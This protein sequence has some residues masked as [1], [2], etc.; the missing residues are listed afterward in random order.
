VARQ[1]VFI[2]ADTRNCEL[3]GRGLCVGE[4]L[5]GEIDGRTVLAPAVR[6]AVRSQL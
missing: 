1:H 4:A 6:S 2:A 5:L 3:I